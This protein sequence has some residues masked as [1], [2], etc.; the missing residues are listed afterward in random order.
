MHK[1]NPQ[2]DEISFKHLRLRNHQLEPTFT[3]SRFNFSED[4]PAFIMYVGLLFVRGANDEWTSDMQVQPVFYLYSAYP[5]K[6]LINGCLV[7]KH[8]PMFRL[9]RKEKNK[10]M[11][12]WPPI[13]WCCF[14]C[15]SSSIHSWSGSVSIR[16]N[17]L[18]IHEVSQ[19]WRKGIYKGKQ[20]FV[21]RYAA[22]SAAES[23]KGVEQRM[24]VSQTQYREMKKGIRN[25]IWESGVNSSGKFMRGLIWTAFCIYATTVLYRMSFYSNRQTKE[26]NDRSRDGSMDVNRI[27]IET[28]PPPTSTGHT[29][30]FFFCN[31]R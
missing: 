6:T 8:Q 10:F 31:K 19:S 26:T 14:L 23:K 1:T 20:V 12:Q 4:D 27:V 16:V 5:G 7:G 25:E 22:T 17:F 21:C 30:S 13:F 9:M 29:C 18:A 11:F 28:A 3:C 24:M 15:R 2:F